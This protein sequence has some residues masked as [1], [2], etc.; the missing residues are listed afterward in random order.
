MIYFVNW[1]ECAFL[2]LVRFSKVVGCRF[3]GAKNVLETV[4]GANRGLIS[5][6]FFFLL[7][8]FL[9]SS[10]HSVNVGFPVVVVR[11]YTSKSYLNKLTQ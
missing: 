10:R 1:S 4:I 2:K 9:L 5:F 6:L 7:F 8:L 11:Y 3:H